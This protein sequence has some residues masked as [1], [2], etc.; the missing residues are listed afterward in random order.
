MGKSKILVVFV[1]LGLNFSFL[2]AEELPGDKYYL[3]TKEKGMKLD[4]LFSGDSL[5]VIA[6]INKMSPIYLDSAEI[7]KVPYDFEW[8]KNWSPLPESLNEYEDFE[9]LIYIDISEQWLGAYEKG[10]LVNSFPISSGR[11][12][13]DEKGRPSYATRPG[14]F[15]IIWKYEKQWSKKFEVW[16]Y[17]GMNFYKGFTI[18]AGSPLPGYPTSHGCVRLFYQNAQ[19]IYK[20][21]PVGTPVII[22]K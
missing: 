5:W 21:A 3:L 8:A 16:L 14:N 6:R 17:R 4:S 7:I 11:K 1:L 19:W 12:G 18:H 22:V 2:R 15:K 20:W 13:I 10:I 9:K